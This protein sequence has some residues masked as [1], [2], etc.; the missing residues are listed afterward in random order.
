MN[1]FNFGNTGPE[2]GF[3]KRGFHHPPS[4]FPLVLS[5]NPDFDYFNFNDCTFNMPPGKASTA[6]MTMFNKLRVPFVF[7]LEASFA[8]ASSGRLAGKH[9]SAG[10]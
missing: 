4:M 6:R 10:D 3:V 7:T 8:G 1:I 2:N 5:K 9:F